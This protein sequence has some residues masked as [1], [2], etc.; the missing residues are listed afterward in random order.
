MDESE[1]QSKLKSNLEKYGRERSK[2]GSIHVTNEV[3][4]TATHLSATI[5]AILGTVLLVVRAATTDTPDKVWRIVSFAVYGASMIFQFAA[6]TLHHGIN[7]EH[8]TEELFRLFDYLAIF[9]LI[10]GTF[11]PICLITLRETFWGWSMFGTIWGLA[12]FGILLKS[13]APNIPKWVTNTIYLSMGWI[14]IV[15][16]IPFYMKD[17]IWAVLVLTLGGIFYTVGSAI[18]Y[19][20]KP[21][22][23]EGYFG[24]HEIWHIFVILGV[25]SHYAIMYFFI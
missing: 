11:T 16:A 18:F 10:A 22:P 14:G 13:I 4:N 5:F 3:I 20:E 2:D 15:L 6:S 1:I 7:G 12:L 21:N 9:P 19:G 17:G 25:A 23:I 8:K 24:F